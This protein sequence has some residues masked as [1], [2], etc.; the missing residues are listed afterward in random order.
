MAILLLSWIVIEC[1]IAA[2]RAKDFAGRLICCGVAAYIAFQ[3]TINICVVTQLMPNT[4][5]PLPFFSYGLTSLVTLYISMG[6]VLNISL[7]RTV[8][9]D[10]EI[11]AEDFRG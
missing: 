3:S 9:R 2:V 11:F 4:G 6:V 8:E 5:L 10:D 1:I 7:Q